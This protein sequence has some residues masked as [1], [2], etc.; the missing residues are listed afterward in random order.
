MFYKKIINNILKPHKIPS[1]IINKIYFHYK[2]KNYNLKFFQDKQSKIFNKLGLNRDEGVKKLNSIKSELNLSQSRE[3]SSEHEVLFSSISIKD[4]TRIKS[5]LEIGT[6][7]GVNALI[8]SKLFPN[9]EIDTIDLSP[10]DNIFKNF[11]N[12]KKP[13]N[14]FV[15][16]RDNTLSRGQKINFFEKNSLKLINHKKKYDLIWIDGAHG[17]PVVCIDIINSLN[18]INESGIITCD[19]VYLNLK[20]K[21]SDKIYNS[22]ATYET[23]NELE[24][25]K[26]IKLELIFK[27]LNAENNCIENNRKFV[28]VFEKLSSS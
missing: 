18:L 9:S 10:D 22:I 11:Y 26:I 15:K 8:L 13:I 20:Q 12:H 19:D 5:I 4:K 24:K 2:I 3:M 27:R 1:K 28:G 23:L 17:Y 14:E 6:F 7:D 25:L 16:D 21:N